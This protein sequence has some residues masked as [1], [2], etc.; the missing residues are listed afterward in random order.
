MRDGIL[1]VQEPLSEAQGQFDLRQLAS[2][3]SWALAPVRHSNSAAQ[4]TITRVPSPCSAKTS[5][6]R[7]LRI[8]SLLCASAKPSP[9]PLI[10]A[11]VIFYAW[12]QPMLLLL[13]YT[14]LL[15]NIVTNHLRGVDKEP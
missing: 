7:R 14:C 8:R 9:G 3:V 13:L 15:I 2:Y 5:S 11:S 1:R 6:V 4:A 10:G 12:S